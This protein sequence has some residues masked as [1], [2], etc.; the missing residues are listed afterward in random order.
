M[1]LA[2]LAVGMGMVAFPQSKGTTSQQAKDCAQN[3]I[4]NNNTG[5]I[6]CYNVDKK[7]AE[8]I[9]QLVVASK[10][11]GKTLRDISDKMDMLL[12]ELQNQNNITAIT[13]QAPNGINIGPGAF[14]PNPQVFNGPPL[15][16]LR[17]TEEASAPVTAGEKVLMVHVFTDRSIPGAVIGLILSG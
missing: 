14:A 1:K 3:F 10:R 2:A 6:T 5:T 11:D 9:G 12:R 16:H 8:Q 13:Q 4:G 7:L 15:P 17:F